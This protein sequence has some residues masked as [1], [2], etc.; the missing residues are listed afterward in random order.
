MYLDVHT[1]L[2]QNFESQKIFDE[3]ELLK[4]STG[5]ICNIKMGH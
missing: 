4:S 1:Y 5:K 2:S 3:E